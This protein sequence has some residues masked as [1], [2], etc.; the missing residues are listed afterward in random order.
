MM[1]KIK[2]ERAEKNKYKEQKDDLEFRSTM[3]G[4]V[5]SPNSARG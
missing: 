2:Y 4:S 3:N 5:L 1:R